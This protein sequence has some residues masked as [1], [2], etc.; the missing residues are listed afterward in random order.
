MGFYNNNN[1]G[2]LRGREKRG[3]AKRLYINFMSCLKKGHVLVPLCSS[4]KETARGDIDL[5]YRET[6]KNEKKG[7]TKRLV[8]TKKVTGSSMFIHK[9]KR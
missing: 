1:G 8:Q 4:L 3:S 2:L 9:G 7:E 5:Q 6:T